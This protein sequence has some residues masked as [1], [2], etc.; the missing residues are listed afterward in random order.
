MKELSAEIRE[1]MKKV[2]ELHQNA[3]DEEAIQIH[4]ELQLL[5]FEVLSPWFSRMMNFY[6]KVPCGK[7]MGNDIRAAEN[8][9]NAYR[10]GCK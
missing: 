5:Q 2:E 9:V 8:F 10:A 3:T 4:N 7:R 1:W 6:L